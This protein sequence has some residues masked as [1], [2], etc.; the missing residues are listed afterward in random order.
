MDKMKIAVVSALF[1]ILI[2]MIVIAWPV[3]GSSYSRVWI[4]MGI[5]KHYVEV[6]DPKMLKI[7]Q[8]HILVVD[9][10]GIEYTASNFLI[11]RYK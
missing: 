1:A 9:E 4:R 10:Y 2:A 3:E 6:R 7:R 5:D 11:K 8:G